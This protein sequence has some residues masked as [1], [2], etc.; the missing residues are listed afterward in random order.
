M[1]HVIRE[2]RADLLGA[3]KGLALGPWRWGT[4]VGRVEG[5]FL[6]RD[7]G[8]LLVA[9]VVVEF[10]R[11]VHPHVLITLRE[12]ATA[13]RLWAPVA[14]ERTEGVKRFVVQIAN[15]L[16]VFGAGGITTTNLSGLL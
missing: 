6:G 11:P 2:G 5:C 16:T 12:D 13:V 15:E 4:A 8:A 1:P 7:G 10:G 9:G 3:W 14:V